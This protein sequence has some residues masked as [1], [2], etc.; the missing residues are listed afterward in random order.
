P[1]KGLAHITGGAFTKLRR[2]NNKVGFD[3]GK[4]PKPPAIFKLIQE[5]GNIDTCEMYRTFNMGI[6]FCIIVDSSHS[7]KV[8]DTCTINGVRAYIIGKVTSEKGV[9]NIRN[10]EMKSPVTV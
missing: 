2:L 3:L 6:G 7:R 10:E 1:V 4:M 9:I 5:Y 8:V